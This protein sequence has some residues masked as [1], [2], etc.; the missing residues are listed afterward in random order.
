MTCF[1]PRPHGRLNLPTIVLIL[2]ACCLSVT[3]QKGA[4]AATAAPA[5]T[6]FPALG[7][8]QSIIP[9]D[10]MGA[11]GP[12]HVM[13]VLN[14]QVRIQSRTGA[15]LNTFTMSSSATTWPLLVPLDKPDVSDPHLLY[16]PYGGRWIFSAMINAETAS[17]AIVVGVSQGSDPTAA[18]NPLLV[19]PADS[20]GLNWADFPTLGFNK[21]WVVVAANLYA[22]SNN[23]LQGAE[24]I[25]IDKAKL[26]DTS[27]TV[28]VTYT[29]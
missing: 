5:A 22:N 21:N 9:P 29:S 4:L 3:V 18:W 24:V 19:I 23:S 25:A 14:S 26:Y 11:V 17:S 28:P 13:T 20:K 6:T 1:V 12:N 2:F 7:D 8:D 15:V 10:T 27:G 16:D